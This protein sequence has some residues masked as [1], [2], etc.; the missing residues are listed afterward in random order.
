MYA[1]SFVFE[2]FLSYKCYSNTIEGNNHELKK[3]LWWSLHSYKVFT[4]KSIAIHR[5]CFWKLHFASPRNARIQLLV[6]FPKQSLSAVYA[7]TFCFLCSLYPASSL[8]GCLLLLHSLPRKEAFSLPIKRP[9][10]PVGIL[11][12]LRC[13]LL[14]EAFPPDCRQKSF[15][16]S[17]NSQQLTPLLLHLLH[18]VC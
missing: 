16:P 13:S 10:L 8:A 6:I 14:R 18:S 5:L 2:A 4:L 1:K 15:L 9:S 11:L 7:S 12:I 17:Q 3:Q